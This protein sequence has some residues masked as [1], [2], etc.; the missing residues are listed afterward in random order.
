MLE[1]GVL[2]NPEEDAQQD[3][4]YDIEF[5]AHVPESVFFVQDPY[6]QQYQTEQP[7]HLDEPERADAA[8]CPGE[9]FGRHGNICQDVHRRLPGLHDNVCVEPAYDPMDYK[10]AEGSRYQQ[11]PGAGH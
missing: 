9:E 6:Q 1:Q 2:A 10:Q 3:D 5:T 11:F 4:P 7:E 8:D